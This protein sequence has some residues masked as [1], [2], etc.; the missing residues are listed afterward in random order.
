MIPPAAAPTTP[1]ITEPSATRVLLLS[2]PVIN[3]NKLT[4]INKTRHFLIIISSPLKGRD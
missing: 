1:P 3:P 4:K 2:H